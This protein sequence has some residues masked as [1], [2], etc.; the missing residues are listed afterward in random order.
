MSSCTLRGAIGMASA[1]QPDTVVVPAGTYTLSGSNGPIAVDPTFALTITGAGSGSTEVTRTGSP[2]IG[3]LVITSSVAAPIAISGVN[4]QGGFA[5]A[6]ADG[7]AIYNNQGALT[8]SADKFTSN[9]AQ[10]ATTV[11]PSGA[12]GGEG[13]AV[14]NYF[15][16]LS[17]T[18]TAF[19]DNVADGGGAGSEAGG[20]AGEGGAIT[21]YEGFASIA[22]STFDGNEAAAGLGAAINYGDG[23]SGEGGAIDNYDGTLVVNSS[24][25]GATTPNTALSSMAVT[26]TTGS[27]SMPYTYGGQGGQGG[28]IYNGYGATTLNSDTLTGNA[29]DGAPA[30]NQD[31][32]GGGYGGAVYVYEGEL[33]VHGG[34]FSGDQALG[35]TSTTSPATTAGNGGNGG[36]IFSEGSTASIDDGA[37]FSIDSATGGGYG[38]TNSEGGSGATGGAVSTSGGQLTLSNVSFAS[39]T[40]TH[41]TGGAGNNFD[42]YS[43]GGALADGGT[44]QGTAVTFTGNSAT[45]DSH[46]G[47]DAADGSEGGAVD[48]EYSSIASLANSTFTTN[49]AAAGGSGG[50]IRGG[51][52]GALYSEQGGDVTLTGDAFTANTAPNGYGGALYADTPTSLVASTVSGN[53]AADGGGLY[54]YGLPVMIVNS[55]I[56][57]NTAEQTL[58]SAGDGQGGGIFLGNGTLSLSSDT[59]VAN[60]AYGDNDGGNLYDSA[61]NGALSVHDTLIAQGSLLGGGMGTENCNLNS[62][63]IT[64]LGY[65]FEDRNQCGFGGTGDLV[66]QPDSGLGSLAGNGGSTQTVALLA[67]SSAIN[68]GDPAGC[69]DAL[70]NVLTTDQRGTARPQGGRCDIGAYE[71]VPPTVT[72][73]PPPPPAPVAPVL[74]GLSLSPGVFLSVVGGGSTLIYTDTEAAT[75]SFAITGTS[76]GYKPKHGSCRALPKSG[77]RPK[78][79]KACSLTITTT[80]SHQDVAGANVVLLPGRPNGVDLPAGSYTLK[81]TP[82]FAGLAGAPETATFKI[83]T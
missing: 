52:G 70:G 36:A 22:S 68:A 6:G 12:E 14:Y 78:H 44:V 32:G 30:G 39:D 63:T 72:P 79:S 83:S 7:G 26:G 17:V 28:A 82:T 3:L 51:D 66:S 38:T 41:G 62:R 46:V 8:L 71:F 80:F 4:F 27:G 61:S 43:Y 42:T 64:D 60:Q 50:T 35:G 15:G 13:G 18:G 25:F 31:Q 56:D 1:T 19:N 57:G 75:T 54:T 69:T 20:D 37:S 10:G 53:T 49:T 76:P 67:G 45:A 23:S 81:A 40:A 29:A 47:T 77:K 74:S 58:P 5:P 33:T 24:T 16:T 55:T 59:I 2:N 21:N 9:T 65:N 73:P 34:S 48:V 11:N